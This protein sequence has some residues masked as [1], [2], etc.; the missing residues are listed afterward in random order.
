MNTLEISITAVAVSICLLCVLLTRQLNH[1]LSLGFFIVYLTLEALGFAFEWLM[2]HPE[3]PFKALWLGL[4]MALSFLMAP[5]LWLFAIET[6]INNRPSL[7]QLSITEWGV[8][9][10]GIV[11]T[12]P[13]ILAAHLGNLMVDPQHP[14]VGFPSSIIHETMLLSIGLF[15]LQVPWYLKKCLHIIRTHSQSDLALF[16]NIDDMPLNTLRVLIW[17][18]AGNW[19]LGLLRTV[20]E[21]VWDGLSDLNV[22]FTCIEAGITLWA[23]YVIMKRGIFSNTVD[24]II[25]PEKNLLSDDSSDNP[26][27]NNSE[28]ITL[29][30]AKS[31]LDDVVRKR[32]ERKLQQAL[33]IDQIFKRSNLKLRDL[34]DHINESTHYVSQVINQVMDTS[35]YELINQHRVEAAKIILRGDTK[36]SV[37]NIAME[38]GFNSKSTFNLAFKRITGLTPKEYKASTSS[39]TKN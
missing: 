2:A 3:S 38:V 22:I 27:S 7:H 13:L 34:C 20:C 15:L 28:D 14:A 37:I 19:I 17:V 9:V 5:C 25:P 1:R 32:I 24:Q 18:M 33:Q 31:A 36:E 39:I 8:I 12:L 30:Y 16:S 35:F 29:K 11:L 10:A 21:L 26:S 23:V 6:S 4:Y